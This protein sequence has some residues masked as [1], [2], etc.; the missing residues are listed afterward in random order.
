MKSMLSFT[1]FKSKEFTFLISLYSDKIKNRR[2][3][4]QLQTKVI[5]FINCVKYTIHERRHREERDENGRV[6]PAYI[7]NDGEKCWCKNNKMHRDERNEHRILPAYIRYDGN[8]EWWK[9]G[10][11]DTDDFDEE[12]EKEY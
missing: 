2:H 12:N 8:R 7:K 5:T 11:L 6:L 3:L 4:S 10:K 1:R 9:N